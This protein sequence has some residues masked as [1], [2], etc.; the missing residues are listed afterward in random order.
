[1]IF[2]QKILLEKK[3]QKYFPE[4]NIVGEEQ[5]DKITNSEYTW[6][7]DPID[8]T[9]SMIMGLPT[10]SNLIGLYKKK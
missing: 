4:H 9:K 10:W 1:M 3:I 6:F 2:H 8:G 5:K 7:I